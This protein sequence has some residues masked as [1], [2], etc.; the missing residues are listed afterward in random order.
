VAPDYEVTYTSGATSL[1]RFYFE[2]EQDTTLIIMAPSGEWVCDDDAY[3]P[4]PSI[5]FED[6]ATGVYDIW[7]GSYA[8]GT[9][10]AGTLSVTE[11]S[12]NHP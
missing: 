4:D 5:D 6:P 9:V 3:F 11:L 7:V 1:L 12:R 2:A 10:H 8:V